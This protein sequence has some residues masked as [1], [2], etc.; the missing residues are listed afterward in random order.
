M[1][2]EQNSPAVAGPVERRVIQ[3]DYM[4]CPFCGTQ[5]MHSQHACPDVWCNNDSC[6]I[7]GVVFTGGPRHWNKRYNY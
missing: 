4:P 5:P 1:K 6:A 2:T 7:V 3:A